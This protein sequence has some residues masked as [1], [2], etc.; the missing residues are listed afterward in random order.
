MKILKCKKI[1]EEIKLGKYPSR[2]RLFRVIGPSALAKMERAWR[3]E[4]E[5]RDEKPPEIIEY[6]RR[7][8]IALRKHGLAERHS[9][10][11]SMK[12]KRLFEV[13]ESD[14]E[15]ALELLKET[16]HRHPDLRMWID[17]DVNFD[18]LDFALTPSGMPYPVW[19]KCPQARGGGMPKRTIRDFK[20]EALEEALEKLERRSKPLE[21][22]TFELP[23]IGLSS[24]RER[25][26]KHDYSDWKF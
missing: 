19:S 13:A 1:L 17:R 7:L 24:A 6:A 15:G 25:L 22:P 2:R 11:G 18:D 3:K 10:R 8:A 23:L 20:R 5:T 21:V 26:R 14:F 9:A 16:L 4:V 12:A